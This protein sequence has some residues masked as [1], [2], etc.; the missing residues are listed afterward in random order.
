MSKADR[1]ILRGLPSRLFSEEWLTEDFAEF[2]DEE[3]LPRLQLT[4]YKIEEKR[5]RARHIIHNL[6]RRG[7]LN[8]AVADPRG[9]GSDSA[10][11]VPI[12][13]AVV[14]AGMARKATGS[15]M[16][17]CVT[18]YFPTNW[19]MERR[20]L[21]EL[22]LLRGKHYDDG[23]LVRLTTGRRCPR[24]GKP[25]P[26]EEQYQPI[27]IPDEIGLKAERDADNPFHPDP[28]AVENGMD[29]M[30]QLED[31]IREINAFNSK[32]AWVVK[33][34]CSRVDGTPAKEEAQVSP[35]L[36][37][38]W[39][40]RCFRYG[41]L[42]TWGPMG[43]QAISKAQRRTMTIGGEPAAE[44]DFSGYHT[45]MIY[46]VGHVPEPDGDTYKPAE[47]LPSLQDVSDDLR[48][49]ARR[50]I[51]TL[52]N[53]CWN[54][55]SR[56]EAEGVAFKEL[57]NAPQALRRVVY[58]MEQSGPQDLLQ[59]IEAA[60]PEL[61]KQDRFYA[62]VGED[63]METD[64]AIMLDILLELARG[65]R[66]ALGIHDGVVVRERDVEAAKEA[67]RSNYYRYI[68]NQP[69]ICRVF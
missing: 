19:L 49:I 60:H 18:R 45:L 48:E 46:H 10:K 42:Y 43:A 47:I 52:T 65:K 56:R 63:L 39:S 5:R 62:N 55:R 15:E 30:R 51:K 66:P 6:L 53:A 57:K 41:R 50:L 40:G 36:R 34:P 7:L 3:C 61:M 8:H 14:E 38:V 22:G 2:V 33:R 25:L 1:D 32:F 29:F 17:G 11:R 13:D 31:R 54:T 64:G 68:L 24:T 26:R 69:R 35:S 67:M 28:D 23:A 37:L 27:S 21:W 9:K 20:Q 4:G 44:L 16:S 59:R 12:W 58:E